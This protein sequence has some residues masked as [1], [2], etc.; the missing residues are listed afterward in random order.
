MLFTLTLAFPP[1]M[2]GPFGCDFVRYLALCY[3]CVRGLFGLVHLAEIGDR[4]G[5]HALQLD[6]VFLVGDAQR[7]DELLR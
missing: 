4:H 2:A 6:L 3:Q 7:E 5:R 1:A